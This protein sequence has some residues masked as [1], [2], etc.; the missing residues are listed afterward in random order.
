MNVIIPNQKSFEKIKSEIKKG[1]YKN[2]HILADFDRTLTYGAIGEIKTPS[3]ISMLRDGNH[4]TPGYA[5]KA[6][7]LFNKYHPIEVD[8]EIPLPE[9]RIKMQEWWNL[10]NKLLI[11]SGLNKSDLKDIVKNGHVKF[12]EGVPEFLDFVHKND[13]PLV[14]LSASGC[15]DAIQ[16][17]FQKIGKDY[18]N[19]V[20]VTNR[21]N[22]DKNGKAISTKGALI[23]CMNKDET[24]L[25]KIPEV[26]SLI[27]NKK[28]VI[29]LG[30][31]VGD[32]GM[33]EGFNYK[34]L[35]KI[36]FLNFDYNKSKE[37]FEDKF[38]IVLEGDGDFNFVNELIREL[39][40]K[41]KK[42]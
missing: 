31:S 4:L 22:W 17:F 23:H 18:P 37:I 34:N 20:Y 14:I 11:E 27:K 9:K 38:D 39:K 35:L 30:D 5:E 8:S 33:I 42:S 26:Y 10:H 29:L 40:I 32:L 13:I 28:N 6:Q 25:E 2:L 24:V 15:G 19:I 36:G 41:T 1:G 21:F 16:M 7:G 12:R 3:I